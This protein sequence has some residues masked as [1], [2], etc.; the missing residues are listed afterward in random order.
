MPARKMCRL[1]MHF[2]DSPEGN[3]WKRPRLDWWPPATE[4]VI[5]SAI[6]TTCENILNFPMGE[7]GMAH[8]S[9][10]AID[11]NPETANSLP[12]IITTA[13]AGAS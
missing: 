2:G 10:A 6:V 9:V 13:H 11:L 8:P 12:T 3:N 4:E 5:R 7:A 1:R